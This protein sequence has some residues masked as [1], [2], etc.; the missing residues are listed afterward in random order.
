MKNPQRAT[1]QGHRD[2][3]IYYMGYQI[4]GYNFWIFLDR[5]RRI[6]RDAMMLKYWD[7]GDYKNITRGIGIRIMILYNDRV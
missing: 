6:P 4:T 3:I 1:Q 2:M 7:I 5:I